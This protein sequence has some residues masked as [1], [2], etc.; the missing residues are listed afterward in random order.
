MPSSSIA[1]SIC[2]ASTIFG[3]AMGC[4]LFL[5]NVA[6]TAASYRPGDAASALMP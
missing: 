1:L 3:K 4:S 2:L 6:A 5:R